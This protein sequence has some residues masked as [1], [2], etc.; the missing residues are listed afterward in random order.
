MPTLQQLT[1]LVPVGVPVGGGRRRDYLMRAVDPLLRRTV[2]DLT[3]ETPVGPLQLDG[4]NSEER[5]L[6]YA[7]HNV[8][9]YYER[10]P[11]GTYIAQRGSGTFVDVGANLGIYTL[12]ARR[13]GMSTV[14]IE[15][16][17]THAAFMQRNITAFGTVLPLALSDRDGSLPLYYDK[18]NPGAT[19]LLPLQTYTRGQDAVPVRTFSG[20][21][22]SGGLGNASA[23]SL[24]KIDVEGFEQQV[25]TGMADFFARGHRPHIWCEVRGDLSGRAPGSHRHVMRLLKAEGY[26]ALDAQARLVP[27][28]AAEQVRNRKVFDLL[29][30]PEA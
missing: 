15:P 18:S 4:A 14:A 24:V 27:V 26:Q 3:I 1:R 9:R 28:E 25:I 29:F 30:V 17:P 23:V 16:E 12:L 7:F 22:E 21:A 6:A 5:L 13:A 10:S 11:L 19:S 20:I 8:W 2:R